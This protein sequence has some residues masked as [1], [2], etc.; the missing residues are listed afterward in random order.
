MKQIFALLLVSVCTACATDERFFQA[1]HQVETGGRIGAIVGDKGK[2]LG[3]FQIHKGYWT[4]SKVAGSYSDVVGT[5]YARK[6]VIA[7]LK[8]YCPDAVSS[9]NYEVM[10]RVHNGGPK[11]NSKVA[12]MS[13]WHKVKVELDKK[14]RKS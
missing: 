14:P 5:N 9:N 6:V 4:D 2:A 3:P 1:L 13:Y 10:A 11:G 7:Y 12:T 8:R